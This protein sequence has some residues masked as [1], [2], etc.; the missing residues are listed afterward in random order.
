MDVQIKKRYQG[1][2]WHIV[3]GTYEGAQATALNKVNAA[4]QY[5]LPFT[6]E[7]IKSSA[8][9]KGNGNDHIVLLGTRAN[10]KQI[11]K[12]V[13]KGFLKLPGKAEGYAIKA[14]SNPEA[15]GNHL[16]VIAGEDGN[17]VLYGA[18]DFVEKLLLKNYVPEDRAK[19]R[20]QLDGI[21]SVEITDYPRINNRGIWTW[22]YV[23][24]DYRRFFENMARLKMNMA[25]IWNDVPPVNSKEIIAYAHSLGIKVI[26][27]FPW[28]WGYEAQLNLKPHRDALRKLVVREFKTKYAALGLDGIYFQTLTETT[29]KILAGETIASWATMLV[30]E[31]AADIFKIDPN[32]YLQFGLHASAVME[33]YKDLKKLDPRVVIMWEN[34]GLLPFDY[35][36]VSTL[37][38]KKEWGWGAPI[39]KVD[40]SEKTLK[41]S[42]KIALVRGEKEFAMVPKGW[43]GLDW[44][45]EFEHHGQ[46]ILG[47]RR[48]EFIRE[49]LIKRQPRWDK[50][51]AMWYRKV[52]VGAKFYREILK[53]KLQTVTV[54]GLIEDGL[55]EEKIQP[56]VH[57]FGETLW[58]PFR[59]DIEIL[60]AACDH[61]DRNPR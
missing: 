59:S 28:G 10:N 35:N 4:L 41:Y 40:T 14:M 13:R 22:G 56:S 11:D 26:Y 53:L 39:P 55:F 36:P 47:E 45:A 20:V 1:T 5:F 48:T 7:T 25:V 29:D 6:V 44:G 37:S 58:N 49:R 19:L 2:R 54:A 8:Q 33:N 43:I 15:K 30:N 3:Y 27:G 34:A 12:L 9:K 50:V 21:K 60:S 57:I 17:G 52:G 16:I 18:T 42:K 31:I 24:Y 61:M 46:F 32:L 51:N 23:I 38:E